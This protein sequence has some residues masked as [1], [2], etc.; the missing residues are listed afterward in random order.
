MKRPVR[1]LLIALA[2]LTV[3]AATPLVYAHADKGDLI[4]VGAKKAGAS[5]LIS[6]TQGKGEIVNINGDIADVLVADPSIADVVAIQSNK[7]YVVGTKLG[8]TNLMVLDANGN[9]LERF[10]IHVKLDSTALQSYL[11]STF[12]DESIKVQ[13]LNGRVMLSGDVSTPDVAAR[14]S[15]IVGGYITQVM[16]KETTT[17]KIVV[18]L[19]RVHGEQQ[20]MLKV[21]VLE[22]NK[23]LLKELGVETN[24][25]TNHADAVGANNSFGALTTT[26]RTGLT[27]DPFGIGTFLFDDAGIGP[28]RISINALQRSALVRTLA[29]PNLTAISGQEAGFL[30]GGEFPVPSGRDTYGN[31]TVQFRAFGV[32]LNFKPIVLSE[33]RISLQ[34]KTEVS[35]LS[36]ENGV[37]LSGLT[38]PGLNIRRASTTVEVP[39]GGGL[40]IGGLLESQ[41]VKGMS[42]LPGIMDTPVLGDLIKSRSF[43]RQE[44]ELV[45][46]VT[47]YL[48]KPYADRRAEIPPRPLAP[49]AD[50]VNGNSG[51]FTPLQGNR[52]PDVQ[53][54]SNSIPAAMPP[55]M[56]QDEQPVDP[57]EPLRHV[58]ADNIRRIYGRK[59][60]GELDEPGR[61]GYITE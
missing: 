6:V 37:T 50:P 40:M 54:G 38:V 31:I 36:K 4:P 48:V 25:F 28:G 52:L 43:N 9:E 19:L 7:L 32:S 47:A 8:D 17:D 59:A 34:L 30:A 24:I 22:A 14:V 20:V 21:R 1:G 10:D 60:P 44:S 58:F 49:M 12:P 35:S 5:K 23:T 55:V 33:N 57:N 51:A 61:Y 53:T 27:A 46:L 56:P 42:G 13:A 15:E 2:L 45:V 11:K 16:G 3:C 26:A 41:T 18:N 39:S 29:E